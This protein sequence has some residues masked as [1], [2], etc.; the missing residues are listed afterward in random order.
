MLDS[1]APLGLRS[2]VVEAGPGTAE[3]TVPL[4]GAVFRSTSV[5]ADPIEQSGDRRSET[6]DRYLVVDRLGSG[7]MGDVYLAYDPQLV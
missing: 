4:G 1:I 6:I 3:L 2:R 7:G 5:A